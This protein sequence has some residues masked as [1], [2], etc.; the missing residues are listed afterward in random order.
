VWVETGRRINYVSGSGVAPVVGDWVF[1]FDS[2][3]PEVNRVHGRI[4][5]VSGDGVTGYVVVKFLTGTI[6][7]NDVIEIHSLQDNDGP[8]HQISWTASANGADVLEP[9]ETLD[10]TQ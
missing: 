5:G 4:V 10:K 8:D 3:N 2:A 7:N 6:A 9:S 1:K